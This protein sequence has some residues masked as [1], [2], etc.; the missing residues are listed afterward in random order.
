VAFQTLAEGTYF[1]LSSRATVAEL[2]S[3]APALS[4]RLF[5]LLKEAGIPSF[6]PLLMIQRGASE[7]PR[8]P[9]DFEVG[10]LAPKD[11]KPFR[12]A[13]VRFLA[14]FPC[15]TTV[16]TGN[17]AGE[18][19]KAAFMT[20]FKAAAEQRRIPTSEFR[21]LL[22]FWESEASPNNLVQVQIGLQ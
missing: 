19:G 22:L 2:P 11:T 7:D 10:I 21:E 5:V 14:A 20:L 8:K 6:G 12:E 15:A 1:F 4:K 17:F 9:F 18:G 3:L 16:A 13:N